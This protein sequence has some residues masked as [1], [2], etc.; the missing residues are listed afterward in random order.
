MR[1]NM[2]AGATDINKFVECEMSKESDRDSYYPTHLGQVYVSD[3]SVIAEHKFVT[4]ILIQQEPRATYIPYYL[5]QG[6]N[7]K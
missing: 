6:C 4:M 5:I 1:L 7:Q 3:R 2:V